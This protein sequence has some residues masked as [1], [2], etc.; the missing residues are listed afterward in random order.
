MMTGNDIDVEAR[1][2]DDAPSSSSRG[3]SVQERTLAFVDS[4]PVTSFMAVV[5]VY[6][7]Y[8]DDVR[9][10]AFDKS[11]DNVFIAFSSI[12]FFLF[13]LEIAV[14][15]WCRDDY[16]KIPGAQQRNG[17]SYGSTREERFKCLKSF[18]CI[19]SFYFW[20]DL[21]ATLSMVFEIP[22]LN[23]Y[24]GDGVDGNLDSARAGKASRAGAKA[25]KILRVV[26]MIRLVRLVK[27]Y[28]YFSDNQQKK[29]GSGSIVPDDTGN[30]LDNMPPESHVGAEMSDRTTKKVIVGILIMLMVIPLLQVEDLEYVNELGMRMVLKQRTSINSNNIG[31]VAWD[32]WEYAENYFINTTSCVDL[33]YTG[34]DD[35]I[36]DT[37]LIPKQRVDPSLLRYNEKTTITISDES[38]KYSLTAAFDLSE[39]ADEEALLG[40]LLTS[41]VIVLL[42]VGTM[43]FSR[44]VNILVILP[45]E[46]MVQLVRE[47]SANPLG[48]NFSLSPDELK[49]TDDGME[50]TMLLR[51]ISKIAGLMRVG[52]GEAGAEIIGK[53]LNMSSDEHGGSS[54][55]LLGNGTKIL[56]IFGFVD[57]RNFTDTTECLQEEVMLFVNRIAHILHSI[58]VQSDGAANKNIGDAFLLTW[59]INPSNLGSCDE[60]R[61]AGDKALYSLLKTMVEMNR[62]EDF[63]CNFSPT[64]LGALY[65]RM[66]GYKCRIGCG[67]HFGWAVE[68]AIGSDKKIDASYISPHVNWAEFLESSTKEYGVPILLSEPFFKLLSPAVAK[69]CRQVDNIKKSEH[70]D[71]TALYTYDA[72]LDI[73]IEKAVTRGRVETRILTNQKS[74]RHAS[75]FISLDRRRS[76]KLFRRLSADDSTVRSKYFTNTC[77]TII[78][79]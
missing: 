61:F 72:N 7:L 52:F 30:E 12:A 62:H 51:T 9:V 76:T 39:R 63:I 57:V 11:G 32:S 13:L 58:V 15:C 31:D 22:W 69:H 59:K 34:F 1:G 78:Y 2:N 53:N 45:I 43:T 41:F 28:K 55:N 23:S 46:K 44:D 60:H 77:E 24:S 42:A 33:S 79:Q 37:A 4:T 49:G 56:S 17:C 50:T 26:R 70:D 48:K 6:A 68:G 21:M 40:I 74:T 5:T 16:L 73:E 54:M 66:P 3:S 8:S 29:E 67:L 36:R 38:D 20:L 65:E 75:T 35:G 71:V 10:L 27:L 18:V 64:A 14:Q 25:A 19:G 47:I